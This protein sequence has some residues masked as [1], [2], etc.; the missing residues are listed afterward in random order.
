M[1]DAISDPFGGRG[2]RIID[3]RFEVDGPVEFGDTMWLMY[4]GCSI[5]SE[6]HVSQRVNINTPGSDDQNKQMKSKLDLKQM[7]K[8]NS[9]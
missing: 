5:Q 7:R 3:L 4:T 2:K 1:R 8:K 9:N 6:N